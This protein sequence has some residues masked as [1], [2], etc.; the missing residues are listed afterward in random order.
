MWVDFL[1][2]YITY[3]YTI[4]DIPAYDH[5]VNMVMYF[6]S[7]YVM[8]KTVWVGSN[9]LYSILIWKKNASMMALMKYCRIDDNKGIHL[10]PV[11]YMLSGA[12]SCRGH[13]KT[14]HSWSIFHCSARNSKSMILV[15]YWRY[16]TVHAH[17]VDC[18]EVCDT[19]YLVSVKGFSKIIWL[20]ELCGKIRGSQ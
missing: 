6:D 1:V 9:K 15:V 16:D 4:Y 8:N 17:F 7:M 14:I 10:T 18:G 3:I 20:S 2:N 5:N 13:S 19:K 12:L 11:K